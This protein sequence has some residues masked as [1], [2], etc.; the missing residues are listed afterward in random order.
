MFESVLFQ[1]LLAPQLDWYFWLGLAIASVLAGFI[2]ATVGGGG[3][4][5]VPTLFTLLPNEGIGT[6]LGT[7]KISGLGGTSMSAYQ[8][9][10]RVPIQWRLV[11]PSAVAAL[12]A[13]I[14]G[15]ASVSLVPVVLFKKGLPFVLLILLAYVLYNKKLGLTPTHK[16][17]M[18]WGLGVLF[19]AVCGLYDGFFGPGTGSFLVLLWVLVYGQDFIQASAHAKIV[20]MG[21]NL[22]ALA[23]FLPTTTVFIGLGLF[24]MVGNMAGAWFGTRFAMKHG[25]LFMRKLL[26]VVVGALALKTFYDAFLK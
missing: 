9:I 20:N 5:I 18:H 21:C 8:Y 4:V 19:G 12:M 22:G 24:M 6:L 25:N 26:I 17:N 15:A 14:I 23:W 11:L 2:D 1:T 10:R 3:M 16:P 13:G 7:N